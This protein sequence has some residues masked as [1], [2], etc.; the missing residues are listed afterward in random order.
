[1]FPDPSIPNVVGGL[2]ML[3]SRLSA[4]AIASMVLARE[5]PTRKA[6]GA[7]GPRPPVWLEAPEH[8]VTIRPQEDPRDIP[9][10]APVAQRIRGDD[11]D[12]RVAECGVDARAGV[13]EARPDRREDCVG[14]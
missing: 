9:T 3:P 8:R 2:F 12:N 13:E 5:P 14:D 4:S 6:G 1:M 7:V 10:A 11:S